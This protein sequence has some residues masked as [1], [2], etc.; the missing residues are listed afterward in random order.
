MPAAPT[1]GAWVT[2]ELSTLTAAGVNQ[3]NRFGLYGFHAGANVAMCDGGALTL[4]ADAEWTVVAALLS[5]DGQEIIDG[6][7]WR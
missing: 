4:G 2:A 1:E 6:G 5:R 3:D 7:D